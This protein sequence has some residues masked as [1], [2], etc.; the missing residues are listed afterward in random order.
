[1]K[2]YSRQ[3]LRIT[4][5]DT[6]RANQL[7]T[8]GSEPS[9]FTGNPYHLGRMIDVAAIQANQEELE[10]VA[11]GSDAD[12]S[13]SGSGGDG[14]NDAEIV[15]CTAD[16][17]C[18]Q[19]ARCANWEYEEV[20]IIT[21][22][23]ADEDYCGG[24]WEIEG[25]GGRVTCPY[26]ASAPEGAVEC[27]ANS[28]CGAGSSCADWEW[29]GDKL[30][31]NFCVDDE[32]CGE[33]WTVEG[34]E[35]VLTCD[36][37]DEAAEA[38][39]IVGDWCFG[40]SDCTSTQS[41]ADW[42][43]YGD[44][45]ASNFCIDSSYCGAPLSLEGYDGWLTCPYG[46]P[47]SAGPECH[48]NEDCESWES[49]A[50][51]GQRGRGVTNFCVSSYACYTPVTVDGTTSLLTCRYPDASEG[52]RGR[53]S[54]PQAALRSNNNISQDDQPTNDNES[55]QDEADSYQGGAECI[56]DSDCLHGE[57]CADWEYAGDA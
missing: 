15:D 5:S 42:E 11:A 14:Q 21:G 22:F 9:E 56:Q 2:I 33:A 16:A 34:Y 51:W 40:D 19:E 39:D 32:Q 50:D 20:A 57:S 37:P 55:G 46:W 38:E 4:D 31:T 29:W 52:G 54:E 44:V 3:D 25:Y 26:G 13:A 6:G 8:D 10:D 47:R 27:A 23:C 30:I 48:A 7:Y 18:G 45:Y 43:Y 12:D 53:S 24:E 28:D 35:G 1:M 36:Y 17:D 49:C 41:C